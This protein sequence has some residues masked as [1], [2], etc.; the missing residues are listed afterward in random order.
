MVLKTSLP[1]LSHSA[2]DLRVS[3]IKH[4]QMSGRSPAWLM[5]LDIPQRLRIAQVLRHDLV[6][7]D[8]A[9]D[10]LGEVDVA[11]VNSY[12]CP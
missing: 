12:S 11:S 3:L 7:R 5:A 1:T 10:C 2:G 9:V 6:K 8:Q 4:G